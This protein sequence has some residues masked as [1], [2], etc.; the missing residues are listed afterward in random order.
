[1]ADTADSQT[2]WKKVNSTKTGELVFKLA[3]LV[4]KN[5]LSWF[6]NWLSWFLEN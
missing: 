2:D 4:F 5:W 6:S 3:E 1:L